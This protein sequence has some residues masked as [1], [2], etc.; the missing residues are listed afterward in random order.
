MIL[1][2][3]AT[4]TSSFL[5]ILDGRC[6]STASLSISKRIRSDNGF[7]LLN[8]RPKLLT[9]FVFAAGLPGIKSSMAPTQS[10]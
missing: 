7:P 1:Q 8:E 4:E 5:L 10:Q 2:T 3:H 6:P 9:L